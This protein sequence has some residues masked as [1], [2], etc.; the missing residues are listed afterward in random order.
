[1]KELKEYS[2]NDIIELSDDIDSLL[3][4]YQSLPK[5]SRKWK[6][7]KKAIEQRMNLYNEYAGFPAFVKFLNV[8]S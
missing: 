4:E 3:E 6:E 7:V 1:M 8:S 5:H 2:D